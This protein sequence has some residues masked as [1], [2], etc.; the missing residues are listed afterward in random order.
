MLERG[1]DSEPNEGLIG[2]DPWGG[3]YAFKIT[4]TESGFRVEMRSAGPNRVWEQR[5]GDDVAMTLSF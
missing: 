5:A 1:G 2:L 3:A 4:A